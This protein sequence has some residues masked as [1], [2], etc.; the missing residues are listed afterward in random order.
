M[1]AKF[2]SNWSNE[3]RKHLATPLFESASRGSDM[4]EPKELNFF[5]DIK[6]YNEGKEWYKQFFVDGK[7]YNGESSINYTKRHAFSDVPQRIK[8]T[9]GTDIKFVYIVRDPVERFTSNFK[10][11][12]TYGD[13]PAHY[14]INEFVSADLE[15]N[16]LI[17]TS[18]YF[19]Q[20]SCYLEIFDLNNFY[21]IKSEDLKEDVSREMNRLF[22]FL[23]LDS[24]D[25]GERKLNQSAEKKYIDQDLSK[26][27]QNDFFKLF[28]TIMPGSV[29]R[30][31]I[32]I[33]KKMVSRSVKFDYNNILKPSNHM[34]LHE[35]FLLDM[36]K[37]K[38]L[39]GI[40][41]TRQ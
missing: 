8:S 7:K 5:S 40:D 20:I 30:S 14:S 22:G 2:A 13:I 19:Y 39:T 12:K 15:N 17:K 23:K 26:Y 41:Y 36:I 34:R 29:K 27:F 25:V 10:D 21:F 18:M 3:S 24:V 38:D 32:N 28:K 33:G 4:S 11:S 31:A 37:F 9:L 6:T 1:F 16:P 35:F